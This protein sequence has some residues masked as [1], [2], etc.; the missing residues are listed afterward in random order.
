MVGKHCQQREQNTFDATVIYS[1]S[2]QS[3]KRPWFAFSYGTLPIL[4]TLTCNLP[5]LTKQML[6]SKSLDITRNYYSFTQLVANVC[7]E[8]TTKRH[9]DAVPHTVHQHFDYQC[10]TSTS[11]GYLVHSNTYY[12]C[13]IN[14]DTS[15]DCFF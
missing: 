14:L 7:V 15:T 9:V 12:G 4:H 8:Q 13:Q 10:N 5:I 2:C 1:S 11:S 3:Y 6:G